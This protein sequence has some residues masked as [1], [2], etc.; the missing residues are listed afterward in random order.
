M[1]MNHLPPVELTFPPI[2]ETCP[3]PVS[4]VVFAHDYGQDDETLL[5]ASDALWAL[6]ARKVQSNFG[7]EIVRPMDADRARVSECMSK[8]GV[9]H[10]SDAVEDFEFVLDRCP[11]SHTD[12]AAALSNVT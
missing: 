1:E 4:K 6:E 12:Y 10:L 2:D 9:S 7:C 8:S 3:A 5:N 11:V